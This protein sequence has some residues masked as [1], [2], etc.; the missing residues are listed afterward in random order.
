MALANDAAERRA[1]ESAARVQTLWM[2]TDD[3]L[4]SALRALPWPP[5]DG[6]AWCAGEASTMAR[7]RELLL[8]D[9]AHP[10]EAMRVAAYWKRGAAD[11]H[12]TLES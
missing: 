10:K 9:K 5:G 12:E 4:V 2:S 11:F 7:V 8:R 6:F 1:F 3:E